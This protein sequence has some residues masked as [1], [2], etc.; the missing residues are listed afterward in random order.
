M[1]SEQQWEP[2]VL[3]KQVKVAPKNELALFQ[4]RAKGQVEVV[5]KQSVASAA[6]SVQANKV[7][8]AD[9]NGYVRPVATLEFKLALQKARQAKGLSQSDLAKSINQTSKVIQD[10]ESGKTVPT[11]NV[12]NLLNRKLSTVLPKVPRIKKL[13]LDDH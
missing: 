3:R 4:A 7:E 2:M 12:I 10:Y 8:N 6:S 1:A 13:N 9:F 5:Q 11:G